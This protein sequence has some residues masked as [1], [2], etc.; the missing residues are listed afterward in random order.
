MCYI[1]TLYQNKKEQFKFGE[2]LIHLFRK[3]IH[4]Q[5]WKAAILRAVLTGVQFG[6]SW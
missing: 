6:L 2:H 3:N 5:L 1:K 4:T